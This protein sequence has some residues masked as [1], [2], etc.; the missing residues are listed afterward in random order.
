MH[1]F[2]ERTTSAR[3]LK[4]FVSPVRHT[5]MNFADRHKVLQVLPWLVSAPSI[6]NGLTGPEMVLG[7]YY[8]SQNLT[9]RKFE[10]VNFAIRQLR[11]GRM[12]SCAAR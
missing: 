8:A 4:L 7:R 9:V 11:R 6:A 3:T 5:V 10:R 1:T 12:Q 2:I